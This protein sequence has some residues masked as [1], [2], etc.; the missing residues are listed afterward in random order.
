M[1]CKRISKDRVHMLL[2][3]T[4]VRENDLGEQVDC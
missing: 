3:P 4:E 2:S 1:A